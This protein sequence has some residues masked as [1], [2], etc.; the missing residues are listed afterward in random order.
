M[1]SSDHKWEANEDCSQAKD[2]K[3]AL[4]CK[5]LQE[6]LQGRTGVF[7]SR[8]WFI[9]EYI[10]YVNLLGSDSSINSSIMV[11]KK[12]IRLK[13]VYDFVNNIT[14]FAKMI[15]CK[16]KINHADIL[17]I[18]RNRI[19]QVKTK[20][21]YKVGDYVFYSVVDGLKKV[22]PDLVLAMYLIDDTYL[23]YEYATP[24]D[25]LR[26][27]Q[28]ALEKT[29][30]WTLHGKE[31]I[32]YFER[33]GCEYAAG[34]SKS[35]FSFRLLFRNALL[36][37][38]MKN[39][40]DAHKPMVIVSNDDCMYT[41]PLNNN[42]NNI[43]NPKFLVLQSARMV[44]Y[45]E[46][47]R[48]QVF[49]EPGLLPDYFLASGTIF[50]EIKERWHIAEKVIVT[51][52]PRYDILSHAQEVYS[53]QEFLK[54]YGLNPRHK[55]VHWS[56]QC[57]VF[58]QEENASN[59]RAIFGAMKNLDNVN[60]VIKQHPAESEK[61]TDE[62]MRQIKDYDINAIVTPKN[63]DTYEQLFVCDLM[64]TRH[65]TTA[66]EAVALG[67]PVI[68]L[69]LSGKPDPVEYV[70]EGVALGVYKEADLCV[71]IKRLLRDDSE[72]SPKRE[73]YIEKYLYKI[74]GKATQRV[75]DIILKSLLRK[76]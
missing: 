29:F 38:S 58:S 20:S 57:H 28:W 66:M 6:M 2:L 33:H 32:E 39:L 12:S 51:G 4:G 11:S 24:Q 55:I 25:L 35:Y 31:A 18:S 21:G 26:S 60:L 68:I 8:Y 52:L 9:N 64:I 27:A 63:S 65:S 7:S 13:D 53:K 46:K 70:E 71:T 50:S 75:I 72:L 59:F 1:S 16:K 62:I 44:E 41:K 40:F 5:C 3:N 74:D 56:T 19:V 15:I 49:Q 37:Y 23:K 73:Q 54:R 45:G 67:K 17:F 14:Q 61:F 69:N 34:F 47:C 22:Y 10:N 36:G 30:G 43:D 42:Y 48:S 76:I